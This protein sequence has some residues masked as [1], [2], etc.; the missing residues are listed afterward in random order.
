M[1]RHSADSGDEQR[2]HKATP[3]ELAHLA[4]TPVLEEKIELG[5]AADP[6]PSS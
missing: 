3:I 2:F 5:P 6:E 1:S 4:A